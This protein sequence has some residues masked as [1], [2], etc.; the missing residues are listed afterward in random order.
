MELASAT[1]VAACAVA[2]GYFVSVSGVGGVLQVPLLMLVAGVPVHRATGVAI[3]AGVLLALVTVYLFR[4]EG[5]LEWRRGG[6]LSAGGVTSAFPG[7]LVAGWL[8]ARTLALVIGVIIVLAGVQTLRSGGTATRRAPARNEHAVLFA[9]GAVSGFG[10]GLS[11]AGGPVFGILLTIAASRSD[12]RSRPAPARDRSPLVPS[13]C[14]AIALT[15][16]SRAPRAPPCPTSRLRCAR[17]R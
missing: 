15:R 2:T 12:L 16:S 10:A 9:L 4:R 11:G 13:R 8:D 6:W 7:A 1:L 5:M 14:P 17:T 3:F